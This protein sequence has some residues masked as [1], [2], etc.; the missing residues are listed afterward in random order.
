MEVKTSMK[1][2]FVRETFM[3]VNSNSVD[4]FYFHGSLNL[5]PKE[6]KKLPWK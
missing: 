3:S 4:V 6:V 2:K 1:S 5:T